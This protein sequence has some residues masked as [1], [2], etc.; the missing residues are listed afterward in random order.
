MI[1]S[2][3]ALFAA[4]RD[5]LR[6]WIDE[7]YGAQRDFIALTKVNQGL[8]SALLR[9]E[10]GKS[11]GEKIALNIEEAARRVPG[12]PPMPW[13]YLVYSL[14]PPGIADSPVSKDA[15]TRPVKSPRVRRHDVHA[16]GNT[17]AAGRQSRAR[18]K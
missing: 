2:I 14:L 6:A 3:P 10:G 9:D 1:L 17:G 11:F 8:L 15:D 4:R 5:R 16:E 7:H 13:G 12:K 18:K